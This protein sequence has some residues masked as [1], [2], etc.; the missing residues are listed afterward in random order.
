VPGKV[1]KTLDPA[2]NWVEFRKKRNEAD[3]HDQ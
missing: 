2:D 1:V 3:N